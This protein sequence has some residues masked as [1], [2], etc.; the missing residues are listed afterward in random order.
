MEG[1][2][3][4]IVSEFS[5]KLECV[6]LFKKGHTNLPEILSILLFLKNESL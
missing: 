4:G 1:R 3:D 5:M 2:M 6:L